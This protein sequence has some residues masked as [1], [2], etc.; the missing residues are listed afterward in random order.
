MDQSQTSGYGE[1]LSNGG[2]ENGG[3]HHGWQKVTN[4][5]KQKRQEARF[6]KNSQPD[7]AGSGARGNESKVFQALERDAEERRAHREA[8][9]QAAAMGLSAQ[10]RQSDSD[11][12]G[13]EGSHQDVDTNGVLNE[14][15]KKPKVKKAKKPKVTV[16][17]A[18]SAIDAGDL[19]AFLAQVSVSLLLSF[20]DNEILSNI[21][22]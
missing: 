8:A 3:P 11:A 14:E 22:F 13:D 17:E 9:I 5:K 7:T 4:P 20:E 12:D 16:A 19:A 1:V 2:S 15:L 21:V 18:A 10:A 6:N